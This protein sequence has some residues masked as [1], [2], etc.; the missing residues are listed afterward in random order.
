LEA[1]KLE[2]QAKLN[3]IALSAGATGDARMPVL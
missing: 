2:V 1:A 3:S